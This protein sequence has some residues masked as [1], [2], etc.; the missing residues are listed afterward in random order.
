MVAQ[1]VTKA[2][3]SHCRAATHRHDLD[4][5]IAT[6]ERKVVVEHSC[7]VEVLAWGAA[8]LAAGPDCKV[9]YHLCHFCVRRF[10]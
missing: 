7:A 3:Q 1:C 10:S 9:Q 4:V 5:H 2:L 6:A 8:I